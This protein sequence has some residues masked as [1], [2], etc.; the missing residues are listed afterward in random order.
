LAAF[1]L[2]SMLGAHRSP[3]DLAGTVVQ[4]SQ[5]RGIVA[6]ETFQVAE[7]RQTFH[8]GAGELA[9][10][11]QQKYQR[12]QLRWIEAFLNEQP[13]AC[14]RT[15]QRRVTQMSEDASHHARQN[16]RLDLRWNLILCRD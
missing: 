16:L 2:R 7:Q 9:F 14:E 11:Q 10:D 5:R 3:C 8:P 12:R 13:G 4:V 1:R 15:L 6:D